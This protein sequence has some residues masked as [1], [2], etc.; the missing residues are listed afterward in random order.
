MVLSFL[1]Y[2]L[3]FFATTFATMGGIGGAGLIIPIISYIEEI[4]INYAIPLAISCV[5]GSTLGRLIYLLPKRHPNNSKRFLID[6]IPLLII[7]PLVGTLSVFGAIL[8]TISH[9]LVI[10]ILLVIIVGYSFCQTLYKGIKEYYK[11]NNK[12]QVEETKNNITKSIDPEMGIKK[13]EESEFINETWLMRLKYGRIFIASFLVI[14]GFTVGRFYL[15]RCSLEYWIEIGFQVLIMLIISFLNTWFVMNEYKEREKNNF[16]FIEGD[17]KFNFTKTSILGLIS[18]LTGFIAT[19][20]GLGGGTFINPTLL[21]LGMKPITVIGTSGITIFFSSMASYITY[22]SI[23]L[24][25]PIESSILIPIGFFGGLLGIFINDIIV[26]RTNRHSILVFIL[27]LI[28]LISLILLS[29]VGFSTS[30][31]TIISFCN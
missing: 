23:G 13:D 31:N 6:F 14:T 29:I 12:A 22:L 16:P 20:L 10:A 24:L 9:P 27:C 1:G 19:Y 17:I 8:N 28:I 26:K 15:K 18:L 11:E 3:I 5:V 30:I 4:E 25:N 2:S 7:V 21:M